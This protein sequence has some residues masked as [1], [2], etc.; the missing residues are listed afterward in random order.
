MKNFVITTILW[1]AVGVLHAQ[2][3]PARDVTPDEMISLTPGM[4]LNDALQLLNT[5]TQRYDN[6][7]IID[8]EQRR[9]PIGVS[10]ENMHWKR[11][12]EYILRSNMLKY[13]QHD[14]YYEVV[15]LVDTPKTAGAG[16]QVSFATREIEINAVFFQADYEALREL[17]IDWSSFI[18]GTVQL[19]AFGASQVVQEFFRVSTTAKISRRVRVDALLRMFESRNRGEIIARPQIRVMDGEEGKIKVG[20]NF[21]LTMQ[22]FAGNTRFTEQ[23]SGIILTVTPEIIGEGDTTFVYLDINAERSDVQPDAVG[24]T[25]NITESRT[26]VLLRDGEETAI[27]GLLSH[28]TQNI[29]KGVPILKDLPW[30]FL[31]MRYLFGYESR[32]VKKRELVVLI[33]A[34]IVPSLISRRNDDSSI[35]SYLYKEK[36]KLMRSKARV[37]DENSAN[38]GTTRRIRRSSGNGR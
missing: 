7:I 8:R 15:P 35:R 4:P 18:N 3:F 17:G 23:E 30:W 1:L 32:S 28:E 34:N 33:E 22:D 14:S 37:T 13:D 27:A 20:K 25:K 12:L 24:L 38:N 29:R 11:A 21:F 16:E 10:V 36:L 6:R 2:N 26:R 5:F 9:Q 31:G 19:Q